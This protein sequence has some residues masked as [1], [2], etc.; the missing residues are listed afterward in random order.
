MIIKGEQV[1]EYFE[2]L[3]KITHLDGVNQINEY[4]DNLN[5][6]YF[7][8][9][10][11]LLVVKQMITDIKKSRESRARIEAQQIQEHNLIALNSRQFNNVEKQQQLTDSLRQRKSLLSAQVNGLFRQYINLFHVLE[12]DS[13]VD[14]RSLRRKLHK[15]NYAEQLLEIIENRLKEVLSQVFDRRSQ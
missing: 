7:K 14:K 3:L 10:N 15:T 12:C 8:K 9:Y 1:K 13:H 5:Q 2:A 4:F 6:N 11:E